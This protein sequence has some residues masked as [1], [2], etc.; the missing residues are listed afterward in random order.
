MFNWIREQ[1]PVAKGHSLPVLSREELKQ[2][3]G[4]GIMLTEDARR[5]QGIML[6]EDARRPQG[7]MLTED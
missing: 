3:S 1:A 4:A 6:T 5:R 2:V 7:I